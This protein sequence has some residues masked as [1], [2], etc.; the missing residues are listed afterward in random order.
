MES[1]EDQTDHD[2]VVLFITQQYSS[3]HPIISLINIVII[4][5]PD[6]YVVQRPQVLTVNKLKTIKL[7][8]QKTWF[9]YH[10]RIITGQVGWSRSY[11]I[12]GSMCFLSSLETMFINLVPTLALIKSRIVMD[13]VS[14]FCIVFEFPFTIVSRI[15]YF[16]Q[17][18]GYVML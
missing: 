14:I 2:K 7:M 3:S 11:C 8:H 17:T 16:S 13:S 6:Q 15:T 12:I 18:G 1:D 10:L 5:S 4:W 9:N